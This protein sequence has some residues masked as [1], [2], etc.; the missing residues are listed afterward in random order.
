MAASRPEKGAK[1]KRTSR[2]K[3]FRRRVGVE[4]QRELLRSAAVH[5]FAELG[6]DRC[7]VEQ[8]LMRA[9]VSRQTFYRCYRNKSELLSDVHAMMTRGIVEKMGDV[10]LKGLEAR[11]A[12]HKLI[13]TLFEYAAEL[14]PIVNELAREEARPGSPFR[15]QRE[16]TRQFGLDFTRMWFA[17]AYGVKL[18]HHLRFAMVLLV[19]Q[20]AL[21]VS[22]GGRLAKNAR[23]AAE[24]TA[25]IFVETMLRGLGVEP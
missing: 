16:A 20:L 21:E 11:A 22:A 3:R 24:K 2:T 19:E 4:G 23:R 1:K 15:K 9:D 6:A 10:D 8:V 5:A 18:D 13:A 17:D 7:T 25:I 14:G 12:L